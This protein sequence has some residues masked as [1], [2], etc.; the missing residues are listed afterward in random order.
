[1]SDVRW[2]RAPSIFSP[3]RYLAARGR[4]AGNSRWME[5]SHE[6]LRWER[7]RLAS[8]RWAISGALVGLVLGVLL[9]APAAWLC[10]WITQ[11]TGQRLMLVEAQGSVWS[12]DA[13]LILTAGPG[14]RDARALPGRLSWT[15]RPKGLG[16]LLTLSDTCCLVGRPQVWVQPGWGRL[17][18][19]VLTAA[20]GTG[21]IGRWPAAIL[22]GLGTPWNTLDLGGMLHLSAQGL[23]L[24][25]VQGRWRVTGQ[26]DLS[27]QQMSSRVTTLDHLGSYHVTL[28]GD[29]ASGAATVSLTTEEGALQLSGSGSW[30]DANGLHFQGQAEASGADQSALDNLLNIIGR[31]DGARSILSIG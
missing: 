14:S 7:V 28:I 11:A 9:F 8:R 26:A 16:L 6:A 31:R 2:A 10:S 25:S 13:A 20:D 12:G 30:S 1:M 29:P 22:A 4:R 27:M 21:D 15:L 23:V 24:E 18:L 17:R 19:S 3:S 5:S